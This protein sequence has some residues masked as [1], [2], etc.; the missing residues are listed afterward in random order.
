MTRT[1][2]DEVQKYARYNLQKLQTAKYNLQKYAKY[3]LQTAKY[4]LQNVNCRI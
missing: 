3:N 4:N 2:Y 1:K